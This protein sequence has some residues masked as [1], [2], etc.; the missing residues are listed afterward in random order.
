MGSTLD[1]RADVFAASIVLWETL[2]GRRLFQGVDDRDTFARVLHGE[3]EPPSRW[4]PGLP[5]ALDK[6]LLRGLARERSK[7]FATARDM[8]LAIE[9]AVPLASA[10]QIAAWLDESAREALAERA[11]LLEEVE[12][13]PPSVVAVAAFVRGALAA[14][15]S[16]VRGRAVRFGGPA[17]AVAA[18]VAAAAYPVRLRLRSH[19]L[20]DVGAPDIV[21]AD[22]QPVVRSP[23]LPPAPRFATQDETTGQAERRPAS[24]DRSAGDRPSRRAATPAASPP[25]PGAAGGRASELRAVEAPPD[26]TAASVRRA[27]SVAM[28]PAPGTTSCDPPFWYDAEGTKR[29]Y[30]NCA[31]R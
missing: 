2:T 6:I 18:A 24:R 26:A 20:A 4:S 21:T 28:P 31:G 27:P 30:R 23:S 11:A 13:E 25:R 10:S 12:R 3:I 15:A 7:R 8:A 14:A 29:Y 16:G 19:E 9:S 1:R 5:P 22:V 17:L